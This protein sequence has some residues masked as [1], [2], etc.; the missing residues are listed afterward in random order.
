MSSFQNSDANNT[1]TIA[2]DSKGKLQEAINLV[3]DLE[4]LAIEFWECSMTSSEEDLKFALAIA[5]DIAFLK[6]RRLK[7]LGLTSM[8]DTNV[9]RVLNSMSFLKPY[10]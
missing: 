2:L 7:N 4:D 5:D 1:N 3:I 6:R 8:V 10:M 9:C